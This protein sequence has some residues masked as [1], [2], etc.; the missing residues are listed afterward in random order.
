M[1]K[2][3]R[4]YEKVS[5]QLSKKINEREQS[6]KILEK[7]LSEK[8][9]NNV[10]L[11]Q[12]LG[13]LEDISAE[14]KAFITELVNGTLRNIIFIDYTINLYSKT[15]TDKMKP[16]ILNLLRISVY[17]I[18]FMDK[19][20]SYAAI[21][22]GVKICRKRG[23]NN[24][25]G[26]VNGVL[27]SV[28]EDRE[29]IF[30]RIINDYGDS[31]Y[32]FSV[33]Y[34]IPDWITAL[35]RSSYGR[36]TAKML[37]KSLSQRP[38]ISICV[39]TPKISKEELAACLKEEGFE[40]WE[41]EHERILEIANIS[42]ISEG[43]AFKKGYFHVMD[44]SAAM[45]VDLLQDTD[46]QSILDVCAAPGGKSFYMA[47][48]SHNTSI[49]T[50]CDI[51]PHKINLLKNSAERL[52]LTCISAEIR[53][54]LIFD[55][56]LAEKFDIVIVDAPCSGLGLL[57]K[58]PDI[59]LHRKKE[60]ISELIEI[61]KKILE[62]SARY[63]KKGGRLLYL[64]CTL[65]KGENEDMVSYTEGFAEFDFIESKTIMPYEYNSDGFFASLFKKKL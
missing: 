38:R 21:N 31:P 57:R 13:K 5:N 62:T 10:A 4:L 33:M 55:E 26:F 23:F 56:S 7:I 41:T 9:Y 16:F 47:Y 59:K 40:V 15:P 6:L 18:L 14:S 8:A 46:N 53:D 51:Y 43:E 29:T 48:S 39:N 64:T 2:I 52:G 42:N 30:Q 17:Q 54:A 32:A 35:W 45:A 28:P 63:V 24:L 19:V 60:D 37:C 1:V 27:R 44:K 36:E 20:P 22:E 50:A 3:L 25:C 61:Q 49:I 65:N 34:S 11:R 58:K 12:A